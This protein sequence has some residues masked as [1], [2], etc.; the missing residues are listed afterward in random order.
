MLKKTNYDGND[1]ISIWQ[2]SDSQESEIID[3]FNELGNSMVSI[4]VERSNI[5]SEKLSF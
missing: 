1:S 2:K 5:S 4:L 3:K